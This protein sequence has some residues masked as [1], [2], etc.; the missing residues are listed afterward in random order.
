VSARQSCAAELIGMELNHLKCVYKTHLLR[1]L[2]QLLSGDCEVCNSSMWHR[3]LYQ[4]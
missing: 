2:R 4:S 3:V 1:A